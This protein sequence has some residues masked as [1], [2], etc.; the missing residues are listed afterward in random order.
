MSSL[1][2]VQI[3]GIDIDR[4]GSDGLYLAEI[5]SATVDGLGIQ[6]TGTITDVGGSG[7]GT[8]EAN[9][10]LSNLTITNAADAGLSLGGGTHTFTNTTVNGAGGYG[11]EC[12]DAPVFNSCDGT[13]NGN[14]GA[15]DVNC[16]VCVP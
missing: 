15:L 9:L 12:E 16:P 10:A 1:D 5:T 2:I 6:S 7:I 11:V 3:D 8:R 4:A 14:A 13:F